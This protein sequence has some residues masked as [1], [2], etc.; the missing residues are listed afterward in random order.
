MHK[1]VCVA[2]VTL[3]GPGSHGREDM[4]MGVPCGLP[5]H[6]SAITAGKH[7]R[8]E[9]GKEVKREGERKFSLVS[10]NRTN[11]LVWEP[12]GA[13]GASRAALR[14]TGLSSLRVDK[15]VLTDESALID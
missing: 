7:R 11:R 5:C 13:S 2:G 10:W 14:V 15:T 9:G 6:P 3:E 1:L 12:R 4:S 8:W